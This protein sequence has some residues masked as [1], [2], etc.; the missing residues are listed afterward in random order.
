MATTPADGKKNKQRQEGKTNLFLFHIRQLITGDK[1]D[2]GV[3][4]LMFSKMQAYKICAFT[5]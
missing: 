2:I 3:K 1:K 4:S 5:E